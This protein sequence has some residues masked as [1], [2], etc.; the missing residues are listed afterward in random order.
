MHK[1]TPATLVLFKGATASPCGG[2]SGATGPFYCPID[3]KV[4]LDTAFFATLEQQLGAQ[5]RFRLGLC[6]RA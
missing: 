3:K 4:Y 2:A 6:R 1:Y 5:G